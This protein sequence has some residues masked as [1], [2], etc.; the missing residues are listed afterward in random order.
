MS[1]ESCD[2]FSQPDSFRGDEVLSM[3]AGKHSSIMLAL[4][5]TMPQVVT[6]LLD[7][8]ITKSDAKSDSE[9]YHVHIHTSYFTD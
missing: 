2:T 7:R 5:G 8:Y 4:I 9:Q 3:T 1:A 6:A